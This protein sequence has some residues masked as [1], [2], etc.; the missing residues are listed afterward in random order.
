MRRNQITA[1]FGLI[2][3]AASGTSFGADSSAYAQ[4]ARPS[5]TIFSARATSM[6]SIVFGG[7]G[8]GKCAVAP[9]TD[10][11]GG[12]ALQVTTNDLFNGGRIDL[13]TPVDVTSQFSDPEAYLQIAVK[14]SPGGGSRSTLNMGRTQNRPGGFPRMGGDSRPTAPVPGT[15]TP[16]QL[17]PGIVIPG[18]QLPP[19]G[20]N[21]SQASSGTLPGA[22]GKTTI[23]RF[24]KDANSNPNGQAHRIRVA[25]TLDTGE[26]L[27]CQAELSSFK[28]ATDGWTHISLPL[29]AFRNNAKLSSYKIKRILVSADGKQDLYLGE[30]LTVD[31]LTPLKAFAGQDKEVLLYD[32]VVFTGSFI[33]GTTG[34]KCSWDFDDSDGIQE[35][36]I[37]TSV[38]HQFRKV[39][40][41]TVTLTVTDIYGI[42]TSAK[43]SIKVNVK[44]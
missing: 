25:L 20:M 38:T 12:N 35:D 24:S 26:T 6:D 11:N 37:G 32:K 44:N 21:L 2:A 10:Y 22:A 8:S 36:A 18:M 9:D 34:V 27:A 14:F 23:N 33:S 42:K 31:D 1:I 40:N 15:V 41:Y 17:P 7:W 28:P 43:D 5:V 16:G 30:V 29:S 19:T 3:I 4:F 13:K 39:G